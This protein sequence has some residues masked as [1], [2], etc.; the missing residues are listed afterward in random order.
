MKMQKPMT[1][2]L[3]SE[4]PAQ[5]LSAYLD[6]FRVDFDFIS[7]PCPDDAFKYFKILIVVE[8]FAFH[9]LDACFKPYRDLCNLQTNLEFAARSPLTEYP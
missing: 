3:V 4:H 5:S 6:I 8:N 7:I 1:D 9:C 2:L